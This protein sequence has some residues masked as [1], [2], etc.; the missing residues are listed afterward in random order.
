MKKGKPGDP[1]FLPFVSLV[2]GGELQK[3]LPREEPKFVDG[4]LRSYEKFTSP[5]D[6]EGPHV[7]EVRIGASQN[8]KQPSL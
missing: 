7:D 5:Y 2:G 3:T 6:D 1:F 4:K 8:P